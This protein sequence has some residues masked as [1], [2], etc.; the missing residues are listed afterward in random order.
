M[1]VKILDFR[2]SESLK[3]HSPG[4]FALPDYLEK[5]ELYIVLAKTFVYILVL[6]HQHKNGLFKRWHS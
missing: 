6:Q 1:I 3:M 5:V 4:T 2:L